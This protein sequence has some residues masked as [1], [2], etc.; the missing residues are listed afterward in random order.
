MFYILIPALAGML[1]LMPSLIEL[2]YQR[3][4]FTEQATIATT[5]VAYYYLGS[6]LFFSLNVMISNGL[7]TLN[8]GRKMMIISLFSV[9]LN[10]LLNVILTR[11]IGY[12]GIP[13]ASSV[14]GFYYVVT[15]YLAL[16][17]LTGSILKKENVIESLKILGVTTIM[18]LVLTVVQLYF[19]N[20]GLVMHVFL[21]VLIGVTSYLLFSSVFNIESFQFLFKH[22]RQVVRR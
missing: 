7:Y 14:I 15:C 3:G 10:V 19:L 9:I 11:L 20:L 1:F 8:K 4:A 6:V 18:L 2:F 22:L 17:K 13:L 16:T 21:S 5:Q 12:F